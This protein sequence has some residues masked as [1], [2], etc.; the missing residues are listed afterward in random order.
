MTTTKQLPPL[1]ELKEAE[2]VNL[3]LDFEFAGEFHGWSCYVDRDGADRVRG[4]GFTRGSE[5]FFMELPREAI[6][7]V[8]ATRPLALRAVHALNARDF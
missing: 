5:S 3:Q 4:W 8:E 2:G 6:G 7:E 1:P